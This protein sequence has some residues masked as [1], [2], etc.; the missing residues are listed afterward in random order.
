M[1]KIKKKRRSGGGRGGGRPRREDCLYAGNPIAASIIDRRGRLGLGVYE[2]A[3]KAGCSRTQLYQIEVGA[4]APERIEVRT[5]T[6]LEA[7]LGLKKQELLRLSA[8]LASGG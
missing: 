5:L 4:V 1:A 6:R 2:L 3:E 7:A 8:S